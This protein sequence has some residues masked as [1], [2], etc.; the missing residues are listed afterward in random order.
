MTNPKIRYDQVPS[1]RMEA[2]SVTAGY[3]I[4]RHIPEASISKSIAA[5][6]LLSDIAHSAPDVEYV[7]SIYD[8][9]SM[10]DQE[11]EA[12]VRALNVVRAEFD[13]DVKVD[14][15]KTTG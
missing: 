15:D 3:I 11:Y 2:I 10:T 9:S 13:I 14:F 7:I 4:D 8:N 12:G 1:L 6:A 5:T